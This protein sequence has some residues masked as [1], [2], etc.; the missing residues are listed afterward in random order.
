MS[1]SDGGSMWDLW[2]LDWVQ[3]RA[4]CVRFCVGKSMSPAGLLPVSMDIEYE[5]NTRNPYNFLQVI[6][7]KV[8][9]SSRNIGLHHGQKTY[10][11]ALFKGFTVVVSLT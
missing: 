3:Q 6:Y 11:I 9:H 10:I 7:Y 5:F 8:S 2:V 1:A 4:E